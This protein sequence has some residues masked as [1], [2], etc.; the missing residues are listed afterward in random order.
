MATIG[1]SFAVSAYSGLEAGTVAYAIAMAAATAAGSLIDSY[2]VYPALFP[3]P[4]RESGKMGD[5]HI[6]GVEEG[7]PGYLCYGRRARFPGTLVFADRVQQISTS[8][9][10]KGGKVITYEYYA[11]V[12]IAGCDSEIS[13]LLRVW[14]DGKI[15][16]DDSDEYPFVR[17]PAIEV[18][19]YGF[20][21]PDSTVGANL[22]N[23]SN[24]VPIFFETPS[25]YNP[26][27]STPYT[28]NRFGGIYDYVDYIY[29][30]TTS[31]KP[32]YATTDGPGW[33]IRLSG[34]NGS[35]M[36]PST[37]NNGTGPLGTFTISQVA[38]GWTDIV[39][40]VN[41]PSI[42]D[43]GDD[44]SIIQL[45]EGFQDNSY[46]M[47]GTMSM[48]LNELNMTLFGGRVPNFEFMVEID[49]ASTVRSVFQDVLTDGGFAGEGT[50]FDTSG[51]AAIATVPEG[52]TVRTP[53]DLATVLQ[54]LMLAYD[55]GARER[56]G[57]LVFFELADAETR[58]VAE[59]DL[60]AHDGNGADKFR[61]TRGSYTKDRPGT[62]QLTY[63]NPSN[64]M[65]NATAIAVIAENDQSNRQTTRLPLAILPDH[66]QEIAERLLWRAQTEDY[67]IR[68]TLP[69]SYGD[70]E[71]GDILEFT[72]DG[73]TW[74]VLTTAV[75]IGNNYM[76]E[77]DA[78]SHF[79]KGMDFSPP[80]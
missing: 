10:G 64:L 41:D 76:V 50:D 20:W 17:D 67:M 8:S 2:Y 43:G 80:D 75:T 22:V 16:F 9:G 74:T 19:K 52:Y 45:I 5:I 66:A 40:S 62:F 79:T 47:R 72:H 53:N 7:A 1:L 46:A 21:L 69:P 31:W 48:T 28:P 34:S 14:A 61:V 27:V 65:S 55:V 18:V 42:R 3:Q 33:Y 29:N 38:A 58:V 25:G 54:P 71:E 78:I 32:A 35:A 57:K 15:V 49:A 6:G 4:D 30:I 11:P 73:E 37:Q 60:G 26:A 77:V 12:V 36:A 39:S 63:M 51:L 59:A 44:E 68:L 23:W 56:D 70:V 13:S 24:S